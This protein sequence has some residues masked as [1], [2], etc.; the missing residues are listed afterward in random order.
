MNR[1][2]QKREM[3]SKKTRET[4]KMRSGRG[5]E[6]ALC[7][8][9]S[10]LGGGAG[11]ARATEAMLHLAV[12]SML[13][14][15]VAGEVVTLLELRLAVLALEGT[16][17]LVHRSHMASARASRESGLEGEGVSAR[18]INAVGGR[19]RRGRGCKLTSACL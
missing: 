18:T 12:H 16:L 6:M 9:L 19:L 10:F 14:L 5:G 7:G 11:R 8:K 2:K 4:K 3:L 17:M 13:R 1:L 15:E